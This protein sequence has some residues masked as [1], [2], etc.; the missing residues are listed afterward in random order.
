MAVG[1][2]F[3]L[4]GDFHLAEDAAQ[5]A[6]MGAYLDIGSLREGAAFPGWFRRIVFKH[7]DRITRRRESGFQS[8][9]LLEAEIPSPL[10]NPAELL[11]RRQLQ[12]RVTA[13]LAVLPEEERL[14]T[15]RWCAYG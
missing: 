8:V 4:T 14:A 6:F 9:E 1:Y 10:G 15:M 11:D 7:C 3:S 13:A 12:E 2:A 5:D